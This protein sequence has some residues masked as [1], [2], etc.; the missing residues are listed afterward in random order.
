MNAPIVL[1]PFNPD[2]LPPEFVA[3][4]ACDFRSQLAREVI[5]PAL[6][7]CRLPKKDEVLQVLPGKDWISPP[8]RVTKS[9]RQF[10]LLPPASVMQGEAR[11]LRVAVT[12]LGSIILWPTLTECSARYRSEQRVITAAERGWVRVWREEGEY[13][14][15]M[16]LMDRTPAY[17]SDPLEVLA[18]QAGLRPA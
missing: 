8:L 6:A 3:R 11:V 18:E 10:V 16:V 9:R 5:S 1:P 4:P 15:A 13:R 14:H 12:A 2:A 7:R 17:P